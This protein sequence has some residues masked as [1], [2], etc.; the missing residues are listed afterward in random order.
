MFEGHVHI[1]TP[2]TIT[3][4]GYVISVCI[5]CVKCN[6]SFLRTSVAL[7]FRLFAVT[8]KTL[9]ISFC[10]LAHACASRGLCDRNW[11]PFIYIYEG[12]NDTLVVKS[13]FYPTCAAR[14][15]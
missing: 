4:M 1:A 15:G 13:P 11:C 12:L 5:M 14:A 9:I 2:C 10:Y 3:K 8:Q 6:I 7:I